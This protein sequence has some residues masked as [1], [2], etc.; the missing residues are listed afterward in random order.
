MSSESPARVDETFAD[1]VVRFVVEDHGRDAQV[2]HVFGEIDT[3][4]APLLQERLDQHLPHISLLV[5]ELSAV[6]FLGS[7][8]L[9]VLVAA[10][11]DAERHGHRLRLVCGSRIVTRALEA[12]GLLD[13]FDVAEGVPEALRPVS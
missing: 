7:A 10:R 5:L 3:V 9:A 2:V 8:G 1:E 6:T 11:D 12:T 13:L 4:T